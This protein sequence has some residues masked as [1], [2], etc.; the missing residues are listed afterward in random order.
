M[1]YIPKDRLTEW[2]NKAHLRD[3]W[4]A[5]L[6]EEACVEGLKLLEEY[7]KPLLILNEN[8]YQTAQRQAYQAGYEACLARLRRLPQLHGFA[9]RETDVTEWDVTAGQETPSMPEVKGPF[10]NLPKL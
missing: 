1:K 9:Q 4:A 2:K 3:M 10:T 6:E 7:N 8:P 5:F